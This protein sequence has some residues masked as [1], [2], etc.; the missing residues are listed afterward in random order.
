MTTRPARKWDGGPTEEIVHISRE[1]GG[2]EAEQG[3]LG[4]PG[5]G[6]EPQ[7]LAPTSP[8]MLTPP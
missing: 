7:I 3:W 5:Q 8:R 4:A 2:Q 1:E 6:P